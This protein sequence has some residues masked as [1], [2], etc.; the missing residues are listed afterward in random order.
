MAM[1]MM[2]FPRI[3]RLVVNQLTSLWYGASAR[4]LFFITSAT[5]MW[6]LCLIIRDIINTCDDTIYNLSTYVCDWS[7]DAHKIM[8]PILSLKSGVTAEEPRWWNFSFVFRHQYH[9]RSTSS[10]CQGINGSLLFV[11]C[12]LQNPIMM[13]VWKPTMFVFYLVV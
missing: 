1:V 8:Y 6:R 13:P 5:F 9:C 11:H 2:T 7:L 12:G 3:T 4:D 10:E